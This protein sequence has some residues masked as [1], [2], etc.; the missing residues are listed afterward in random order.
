ML[1]LKNAPA[2]KI[3]A[4]LFKA[5]PMPPHCKLERR[6]V[7]NLL[8]HLRS[9]GFPAIAT[10]DGDDRERVR[11]SKGAM[12]F[13]FNL[14]EVSVRFKGNG[15]SEHGVLLIL[16]EGI[17]VINDWNYTEGDPD[18]FDAAMNAFNAEDYA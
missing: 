16:G 5:R 18:G 12:E 11:S 3:D 13:I 7:W 8:E 1:W 14:D 17:D 10:F 15:G 2:L 9:K 6:I 4:L